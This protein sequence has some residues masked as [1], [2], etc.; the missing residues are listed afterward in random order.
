VIPRT[1]QQRCAVQH[2]RGKMPD[3]GIHHERESNHEN[4]C[5][6]QHTYQFE[7]LLKKMSHAKSSSCVWKKGGKDL[8]GTM[9]DK[10]SHACAPLHHSGPRHARPTRMFA[11]SG[12]PSVIWDLG[13]I[14]L[15]FLSE[16]LA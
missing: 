14:P 6:R 12:R 9:E 2:L 5:H 3:G 11:A 16:Q 4:E 13:A 10:R 8:C 7:V 1:S 15:R